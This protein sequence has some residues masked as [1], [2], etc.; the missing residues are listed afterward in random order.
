[1]RA[2]VVLL[3]ALVAAAGT[4]RLGLWQ[5]DRAAQ[6]V[7]LHEAQ[8]RQRSR[9][10]LAAADL[11]RDGAEATAQ[12]HRNVVLQGEWLAAHTVFL[13]N[14]QMN[15]R[16]GFFAVTPLRLADGSAVLVERGWTPRDL[17]DRT[18]V[19]APPAP[20]GMVSVHGRIAPRP[21]RLY[22]FDGAASGAIRQNLD[23]AA[24]ARETGLTLR[25]FS[26]VQDDGPRPSADGLLRQWPAPTADVQKHYGYAFQWFALCALIIGLY[27]WFQLIRPR[28][29]GRAA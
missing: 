17:M 29:L 18:R 5:L 21:G 2:A 9:P 24:F 1:M 23:I 7:A 12:V 3:A 19:A 6:K 11:A 28:R 27:V 14:R 10:P 4:A 20:D 25:T 13:E 26:I 16:P 8:Q 22:E 15:G